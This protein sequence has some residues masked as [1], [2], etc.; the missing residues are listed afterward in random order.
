MIKFKDYKNLDFN[1]N[2]LFEGFHILKVEEIDE[3]IRNSRDNKLDIRGGIRIAIYPQEGIL[4]LIESRIR[5]GSLFYP[6]ERYFQN[7]YIN[8]FLALPERFDF[9]VW[10][11]SSYLAETFIAKFGDNKRINVNISND[12]MPYQS[13]FIVSV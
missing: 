11:T 6:S 9:T 8:T 7:C 4:K 2:K 3:L 10:F 5:K 13:L 12:S 1:F